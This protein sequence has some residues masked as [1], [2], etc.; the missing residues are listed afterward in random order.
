[1]IAEKYDMADMLQE[2]SEYLTQQLITCIGNKRNLL[3]FISQALV[4]VKKSLGKDKLVLLDLFSGSGVVSRFFKQH[5]Q[6]LISND[7]ELYANF[8]NRCY[9]LSFQHRCIRYSQAARHSL[10]IDQAACR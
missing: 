2:Q 3:G 1:M 7:L 10:R 5:S 6:K 4:G 8:I 9:L